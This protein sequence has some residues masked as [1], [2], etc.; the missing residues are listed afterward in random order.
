MLMRSYILLHWFVVDTR[1]KE[2]YEQHDIYNMDEM[3]GNCTQPGGTKTL[4]IQT[5]GA[6]KVDS[7]ES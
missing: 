3:P 7:L 2:Q 4:L 5:N 1:K 6:K